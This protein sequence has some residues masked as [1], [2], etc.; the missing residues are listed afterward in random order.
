LVQEAFEVIERDD[1]T[2]LTDGNHS[3]DSDFF[4]LGSGSKPRIVGKEVNSFGVQRRL[5]DNSDETIVA[6]RED[7]HEIEEGFSKSKSKL[8]RQL[9]VQ[10]QLSKYIQGITRIEGSLKEELHSLI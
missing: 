5:S 4:K 7:L 1:K 8:S 10:K 3:D 2:P 9:K 6:S